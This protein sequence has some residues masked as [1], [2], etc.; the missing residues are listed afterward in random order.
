[1]P[2]TETKRAVEPPTVASLD[3]VQRERRARI[4]DAAVRLMLTTEYERIQMKDVT[5]AAGVALGTTYRY[6]A[7]KEH[8]FAE[9]LVAWAGRFPEIGGPLS[10][11][12]PV[13]QLR[14]AYRLAVRAFEP[15]PTVY[16]ALLVIQTTT[17]PRAAAVYDEF[18]A[19]QTDAFAAYL[20]DVPSPRREE[21]VMVMGAVLDVNLRA[22]VG[23]RVPIG[24]VYRMIDVAAELL[25]GDGA[26]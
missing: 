25:L 20:P 3:D 5:A 11:Q 9:A 1:M 21:I 24:H 26:A 13:D 7:S 18:A 16:G 19:R 6:F 15:H 22:W 4:V 10:R 23:G 14:G 12:R 8:L 2:R 17:D